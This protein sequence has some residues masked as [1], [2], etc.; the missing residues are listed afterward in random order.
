MSQPWPTKSKRTLSLLGESLG[1]RQRTQYLGVGS[2]RLA[3]G[4]R[5][6]EAPIPTPGFG[7]QQPICVTNESA[8]SENPTTLRGGS[9]A[10]FNPATV[11]HQ[12]RLL[13]SWRQVQRPSNSRRARQT[14]KSSR[15]S[16]LYSGTRTRPNNKVL[17]PR[18]R[19]LSRFQP[20]GLA[21]NGNW[22]RRTRVS[23]VLSRARLGALNP[24]RNVRLPATRSRRGLSAA[25]SSEMCKQLDPA[26]A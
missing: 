5:P 13:S 6:A 2:Q 7:T 20:H 17:Q 14:V 12:Q 23:I 24:D 22:W 19:Q 3:V 10:P 21:A 9:L 8:V 16:G 18:P 26:A 11:L 25:G 1:Q 4:G 15:S